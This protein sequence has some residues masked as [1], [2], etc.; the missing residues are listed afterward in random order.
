MVDS[1]VW[2][3]ICAKGKDV[4]RVVNLANGENR[5]AEKEEAA[6]DKEDGKKRKGGTQ[7][8]AE[9]PWEEAKKIFEQPDV[10]PADQIEVG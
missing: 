1:R 7:V 2:W 6:A 3:S 10:T 9:W 8:P 5:Q 4:S